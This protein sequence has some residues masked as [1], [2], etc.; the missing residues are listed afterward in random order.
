METE[1]SRFQRGIRQDKLQATASS[2][3][4]ERPIQGDYPTEVT[5]S[6]PESSC[7][8]K[9]GLLREKRAKTSEISACRSN[10]FPVG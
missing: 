2:T 5:E 6:Q 1:K 9:T 3:L 10:A 4:Q 8:F 7:F